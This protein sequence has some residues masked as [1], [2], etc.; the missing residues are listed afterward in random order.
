[1]LEELHN[2]KFHRNGRNTDLLDATDVISGL[3]GGSILAAYYAAFGA[4]ELPKFE[5]DFLRQN[6]QNSLILQALRPGS[7]YDLTSLWYGRTHLQARRLDEIYEGKTYADVERNPRHPQLAIAATDMSLGTPFEFTADLRHS[8]RQRAQAGV[9]QRQFG[10]GSRQQHR[11]ERQA[12]GRQASR[13]HAFVR[14]RRARPW[15][16][17]NS[18]STPP[19]SGGKT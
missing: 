3:S 18:C 16:H 1:V 17:R 8:A 11:P 12:A 5:R 10:A 15:R 2:T 7:L 14:R 6:F 9:H 4:E 19:A 13:R